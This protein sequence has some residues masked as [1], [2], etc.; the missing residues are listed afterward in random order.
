MRLEAVILPDLGTGLDE[1]MIVSHWFASRG[2]MIGE[3]DRLVEILIGPATFDVQAPRTGRLTEIR[4]RADDRVQ[5]GSVLGLLAVDEAEP[6]E[7]GG[8]P[9]PRP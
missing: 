9:R 3:G 5:P 7:P 6:P 1:P 2:Q 4:N 8:R